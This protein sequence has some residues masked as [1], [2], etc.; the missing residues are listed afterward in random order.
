MPYLEVKEIPVG[1]RHPE[2]SGRIEHYHGSVAEEGFAD[3][4]VE[5]VHQASDLSAQ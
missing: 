2:F 1:M 3:S 5:G 4:K